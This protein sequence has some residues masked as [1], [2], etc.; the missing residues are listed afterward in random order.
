MSLKNGGQKGKTGSVWRLVAV[1]GGGY[2]ERVE[3]GEY[4]GNVMYSCIKMEKRDLLK[5]F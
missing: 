5:L 2:K 3:E 1:G 4:G